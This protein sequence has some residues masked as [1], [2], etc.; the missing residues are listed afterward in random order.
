MALNFNRRKYPKNL[1]LEAVTLARAKSR[2]DLLKDHVHKENDDKTVFLIT[3]YHPS[4]FSVKNTIFKNWDILGRSN[5]TDFIHERKLMVGYRRP[6]NL[7]DLLVRAQLKHKPGDERA[8]PDYNPDQDNVNI[9]A[10]NIDATTSTTGPQSKIT[11]YFRRRNTTTPEIMVPA[12]TTNT[13]P[14]RTTQNRGFKFCNKTNCKYC[15]CLNKTGT[16][17]CHVTNETFI[18]MKNTSCRSSNVI[19]CISCKLC[20][21]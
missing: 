2:N 17:T 20:G 18:T 16:I 8:R 13:G 15:K 21:K 1:L 14:T 10:Q 6:K 19:Y 5:T 12:P 7:R 11:D 9:I 4:D 3:T